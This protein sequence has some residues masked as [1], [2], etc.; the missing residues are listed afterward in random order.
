[1]VRCICHV[2]S[3][4]S[5]FSKI[6]FISKCLGANPAFLGV[7]WL[8]EVVCSVC[9]QP[10]TGSWQGDVPM[11]MLSQV[12]VPERHGMNVRA[13]CIDA[14]QAGISARVIFSQKHGSPASREEPEEVSSGA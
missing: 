5:A 6:F 11:Q 1:M 13:T 14:V 8:G 9:S 7:A 4:F 12:V 3:F 2:R 10:A